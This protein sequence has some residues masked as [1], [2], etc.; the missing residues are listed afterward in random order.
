MAKPTGPTNPILKNFIQEIRSLGYK[1]K[2]PFLLKIADELEISK[3]QRA[4]VDLSDLNRI[5]KENETVVVPGK[6]LASGILKKPLTV[7]AFSFSMQA[8][9]KIHKAKGKTITIKELIEKNPKGTDVRVV[10]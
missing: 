7:A 3:R 9:E 5:C 1:E 10:I 8:V 4:E 2:M 6:V